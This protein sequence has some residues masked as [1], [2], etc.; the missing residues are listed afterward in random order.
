MK[1][2]YKKQ[3]QRFNLFLG[4][5]WL[6][7]FLFNLYE[8]KELRLFNVMWLILSIIYLSMYF[9][10]RKAKY[11]TIE[12][13]IIKQNVLFGTYVKIDDITNIKYFAGEYTLSTKSG[14]MKINTHHIDP[15]YF[16]VLKNELLKIK[17]F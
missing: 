6:I 16:E 5:I 4:I 1:I 3:H 7:H 15:E 8:D 14:G 11:L 2:P 17:E 10:N 12:N 9:Y 13:G